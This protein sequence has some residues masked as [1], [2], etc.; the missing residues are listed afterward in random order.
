MAATVSGGPPLEFAQV[1]HNRATLWMRRVG[2]SCVFKEEVQIFQRNDEVGPKT[3][4]MTR[5]VI[6][7]ALIGR[8]V[9]RRS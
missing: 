9:E 6:G 3:S 4:G 5:I 7:L 8:R 1:E 2:L